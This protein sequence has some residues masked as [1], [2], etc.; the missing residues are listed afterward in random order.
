MSNLCISDGEKCTEVDSCYKY[1]NSYSC[2]KDLD[3]HYCYWHPGFH[4]CQNAE[5]CD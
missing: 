5:T 2:T 1:K 4:A 3:N